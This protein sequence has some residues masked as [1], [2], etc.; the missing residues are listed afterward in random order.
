MP[1]LKLVAALT[2]FALLAGGVALV[3]SLQTIIYTPSNV[4]N[5]TVNPSASPT[6]TATHSPSPIAG[7]MLLSASVSSP[8]TAGDTLNLSVQLSPAASATVVLYNG[9]VAVSEAVANS[10]GVASFTLPNL[11][12]GDYVF[13]A[14]VNGEVPAP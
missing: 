10:A 7:S 3:F 5:I 14:R 4:I 11:A 8:L 6:P 13:Q 1:S 9:D 2:I 12:A